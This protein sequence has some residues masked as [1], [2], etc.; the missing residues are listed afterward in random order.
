[1][2]LL[3]SPPPARYPG[4][5]HRHRH[6]HRRRLPP[7]CTRPGRRDLTE[8][9][10]LPARC[11]R[12]APKT[13][14][15]SERCQALVVE[16]APRRCNHLTR[17]PIA[18]QATPRERE[19]WNSARVTTS[20]ANACPVVRWRSRSSRCRCVKLFIRRIPHRSEGAR[21]V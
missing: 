7:G 9:Q 15:P 14:Q 17:A 8:Q 10:V 1:M 11:H 2:P 16:T 3:V 18:R 12:P 4:H 20:N 19:A 13:S 5:F 6:R 21:Y